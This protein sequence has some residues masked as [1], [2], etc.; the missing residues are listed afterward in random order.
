METTGIKTIPK[1]LEFVDTPEPQIFPQWR[2]SELTSKALP[3]LT[4]HEMKKRK[5][6]GES[7]LPRM[8]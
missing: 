7:P 4:D 8:W 2:K 1:H 6:T 5:S 3:N